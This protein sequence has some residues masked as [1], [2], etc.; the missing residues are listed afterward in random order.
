[1]EK[2][3]SGLSAG[4]V[5]SV[6]VRLIAERESEIKSFVNE[7]YFSVQANFY[8]KDGSLLSSVLNCDFKKIS[9]LKLFLEDYKNTTFKIDTVT[10]S[11]QKK[12]HLRHLLLQPYSK[13]LL[14]N[15]VTLLVRL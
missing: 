1:M 14:L 11:P 12:D 15:L 13:L 9:D 7:N 5:Q 6:A 3:K 8:T 10:Q 2:V 4:R